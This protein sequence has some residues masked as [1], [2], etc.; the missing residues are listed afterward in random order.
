MPTSPNTTQCSIG[1]Y[2]EELDS[3]VHLDLMQVFDQT[4]SVNFGM[5]YNGTPYGDSVVGTGYPVLQAIVNSAVGYVTFNNTTVANL[6][7]SA[8]AGTYRAS[9]YG[10]LTTAFAATTVPTVTFG[11]T[12]DQA[13]ATVPFTVA[14]VTA[15]ANFYGTQLFRSAA[16]D[17]ISY[18]LQYA[19]AKTTTA[20][21]VALSITLERLI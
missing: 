5:T 14:A 7:A 9:F 2:Q 15:G 4:R 12:D 10:V 19:A 21:V 18:T 1:S 17:A 20:G 6:I 13:A 11:W 3:I 8:V 16:G